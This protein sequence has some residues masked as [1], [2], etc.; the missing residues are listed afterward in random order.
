MKRVYSAGLDTVAVSNDI[1]KKKKQKKTRNCSKFKRF[2]NY[3]RV[4]LNNVPLSITSTCKLLNIIVRK[5]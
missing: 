4:S 2:E 1:K 3:S 5:K